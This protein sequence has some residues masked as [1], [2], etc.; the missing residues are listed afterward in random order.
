MAQGFYP[1][2]QKIEMD[3][4]PALVSGLNSGIGVVI[5]AEFIREIL[6]SDTLQ[7]DREAM[8]AERRKPK[9]GQGPVAA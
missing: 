7:K 5:P 9:P 2:E 1:A 3:H 4:H 6:M 8:L